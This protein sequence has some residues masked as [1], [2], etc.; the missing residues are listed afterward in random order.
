ML[1]RALSP[2]TE[3]ENQYPVLYF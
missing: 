2:N 3:R 1:S